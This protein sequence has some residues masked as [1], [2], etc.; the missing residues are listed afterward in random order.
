ME[1]GGEKEIS[2]SLIQSVFLFHLVFLAQAASGVILFHYKIGWSLESIAYF[3]IGDSEY[4]QQ[5]GLIGLVEVVGPHLMA[6]GVL[7]FIVTH[8]LAFSQSR[9]RVSVATGL[10]FFIFLDI[11]AGPMI[12]LLGPSFAFLKLLGF[13]GF[14]GFLFSSL[15]IILIST[16]PWGQRRFLAIFKN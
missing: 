15:L 4:K 9:Y 14:Q 5:Q 12:R 8:F 2:K 7:G 16:A 6:M 13:I 11:W 1:D 10:W 3:Y